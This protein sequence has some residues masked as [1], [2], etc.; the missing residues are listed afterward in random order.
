M[1]RRDTG[2][3]HDATPR[4]PA[5]Q[6]RAS[7]VD[8]ATRAFADRG[9]AGT[10]T[11]RIAREANVNEALLFRHFGS[12]QQLYVACIDNAWGTLRQRVDE[13]CDGES[14]ARRWR[15]PG[16]AFIELVRSAPHVARVWVRALVETTGIAA[17]DDHLAT[18]MRDVHAYVADMVR[19]S[20]AAG[21]VVDGRD[22]DTEAWSIIAL[23]LLGASLGTRGLVS[24]DTF[25]QVLASH[26][27]WLTGGPE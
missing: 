25:D 2:S 24:P 13:L 20:A 11:A 1:S 9:F 19:S 10:T 14:P 16:R 15:M 17:I 22:P 5:A 8:A 7:I 21:G 4:M 3:M 26:R 23:G 6:R 18:L 27:E 12:K